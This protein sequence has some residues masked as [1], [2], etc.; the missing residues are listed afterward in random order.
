MKPGDISLTSGS[1]AIH[2]GCRIAQNPNSKF[3]K[4]FAGSRGPAKIYRFSADNEL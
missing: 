4:K 1:M 3:I 2:R